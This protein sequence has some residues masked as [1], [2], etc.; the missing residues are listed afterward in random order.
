[1]H[2]RDLFAAVLLRVVKGKAADFLARGAGNQLDAVGHLV[3]DHILDALVQIL[4]VL[5]HNDKVNVVKPGGYAR[6][7]VHRAQIGI[8]RE[9]LA[10]LHIDAAEALAD[11]GG[12]GALQRPA[13]CLNGIQRAGGDELAAFGGVLR[14][15][16]KLLPLNTGM[17]CGGN[18]ADALGN[19]A[20]DAITGNQNCFHKNSYPFP[21]VSYMIPYILP[22]LQTAVNAHFYTLR[23][24]L[25][26]SL[27]F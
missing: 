8:G 21:Y 22:I 11:R 24:I 1:M 20:A 17:Q 3:I 5:A 19:F 4:G 2:R 13:I 12:G 15:G 10:Q 25:P 18:G 9:P 6:Q 7:R 27:I 14:T 23:I 26:T 16:G